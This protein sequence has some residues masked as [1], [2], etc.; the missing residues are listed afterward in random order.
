[1]PTYFP[2]LGK[3]IYID[4]AAQII[5]RVTVGDYSTMAPY[6]RAGKLRVLAVDGARRFPA[7]PEVPNISDS[8]PGF[9]LS[10]MGVMVAPRGT[11]QEVIRAAQRGM[12]KIVNDKTYQDAL[13]TMGFTIDG[14]GTP[15]SIQ[16]RVR[17]RR[18]YWKQVFDGLA[19]KPE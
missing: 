18:D 12:E 7:W 8:F 3:K 14:A 2:K 4:P 16:K 10:G 1:M 15:E 5:G 17:E 6:A 13:L 9:R 19:I 11:P